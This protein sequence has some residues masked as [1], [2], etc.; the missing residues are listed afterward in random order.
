[1]SGLINSVSSMGT[2]P[3]SFEDSLI[4][5]ISG[6]KLTDSSTPSPTSTSETTASCECH[7][8]EIYLNLNEEKFYSK[9]SGIDI[10]INKETSTLSFL[11]DCQENARFFLVKFE[12]LLFLIYYCP[13][14]SPVRE[15]MMYSTAKATVLS[16]FSNKD[17]E[18]K[19][20]I[21]VHEESEMKD[22]LLGLKAEL[23]KNESTNSSSN[24]EPKAGG[25]EGTI[26]QTTSFSKPV[27]K[28]RGGAR[29]IKGAK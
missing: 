15:K 9:D 13:E 5:K 2:V 11:A 27:R 14:S 4:E 22:A 12:A 3:F 26:P 20:F 18:I 24:G 1:M 6:L 10:S 23:S 25:A 29:L 16:E 7:V 17:I 21:E 28:G 8:L 19:K